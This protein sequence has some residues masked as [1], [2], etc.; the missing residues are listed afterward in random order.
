MT[1]SLVCHKSW[2]SSEEREGRREEGK[3]G[4]REK[5]NSLWL[6]AHFHNPA[7]LRW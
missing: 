4:G 7:M 5:G 1:F 2:P 3:K 6:R